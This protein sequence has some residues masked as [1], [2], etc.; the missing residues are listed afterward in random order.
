MQE[1]KNW[2]VKTGDFL[3]RYR[4][5]LFPIFLILICCIRPPVNEYEGKEYFEQIKDVFALLITLVGLGIR[6]A[7]IGYKYIKR[8]G[9]N[10]KVYAENL[11][12]DG[13]FATCRNPL[14]V[15]NMAMYLGIF[16]MHGD[17]LV[18]AIGMGVFFFIY[19]AI[20]AAEEYFL[21]NKFGASYEEYCRD[22]PRWLPH[23]GRL[24]GAT[25]GMQFNWGRVIAKDYT[26][27]V[28]G[29][30]SLLVIECWE[31][32][33]WNEIIHWEVVAGLV[34]GFVAMLY[35]VKRAKKR[36]LFGAV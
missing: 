23:L 28:N 19:T 11:V 6:A 7:V 8:G 34:V 30:F 21:R 36:G 27:M 33:Q 15:G 18:M 2:L 24:K 31:Q 32:L 13:F 9:L 5:V 20:I 3:F 25:E 14:Y 35:F 29:L 17:P 16:L 1:P 22:V 4:N 10:K 12:T 26:T